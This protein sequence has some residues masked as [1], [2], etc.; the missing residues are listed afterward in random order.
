MAIGIVSKDLAYHTERFGGVVYTREQVC[1][2]ATT[3]YNLFPQGFER[4]A[5]VV[6]FRGVM[7]GA[8]TASD[9][10]RL[11]AVDG[12]TGTATNITEAIDVS[13]LS[14]NDWFSAASLDDTARSLKVGDYLRITTAGGTT[15]TNALVTVYVELLPH[16]ETV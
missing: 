10:V 13:A 15:T 16:E 12:T 3:T 6:G 7:T 4:S 8:G 5:R 14:D 2:A 9:T 1:V 11:A